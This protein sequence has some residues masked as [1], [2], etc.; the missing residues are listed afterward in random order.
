MS[1][2]PHPIRRDPNGTL[3]R[4]RAVRRNELAAANGGCSSVPPSF[5]YARSVSSVALDVAST[6]VASNVYV[7]SPRRSAAVVAVRIPSP[8]SRSNVRSGSRSPSRSRSRAHSPSMASAGTAVNFDFDGLY[9]ATSPRLALHRPDG[10]GLSAVETNAFPSHRRSAKHR[11]IVGRHDENFDDSNSRLYSVP[12]PPASVRAPIRARWCLSEGHSPADG[13]SE[14]DFEESKRAH[15]V[16][17]HQELSDSDVTDSDSDFGQ[18]HSAISG[19]LYPPVSVHPIDRNSSPTPPPPPPPCAA[20]PRPADITSPVSAPCPPPNFR[21][22][23]RDRTR[24][25]TSEGNSPMFT[26]RSPSRAVGGA[27]GLAL[28]RQ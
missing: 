2:V 26:S 19:A 15:A 21:A 24:S 10:V 4:I 20:L 25:S 22:F 8:R 9:A 18:P 11:G 28:D 3:K 23:L 5:S 14:M 6:P 13:S 1:D 12:C 17:R 7:A 27:G 16:S